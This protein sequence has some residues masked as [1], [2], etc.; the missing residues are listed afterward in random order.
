MAYKSFVFNNLCRTLWP[1]SYIK[2]VHYEND[3]QSIP[4]TYVPTTRTKKVV[5]NAL[6]VPR[7]RNGK[8]GFYKNFRG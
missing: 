8:S 7:A 5:R 1:K 6:N 4:T 3:F 2:M